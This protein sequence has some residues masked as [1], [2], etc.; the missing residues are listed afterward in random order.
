MAQR[1]NL[2][3]GSV[4]D[5]PIDEAENRSARKKGRGSSAVFGMAMGLDMAIAKSLSS[6]PTNK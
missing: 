2:K 4:R 6:S 3:V 1:E 5:G